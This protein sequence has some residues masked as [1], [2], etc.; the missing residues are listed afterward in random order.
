MTTL[1]QRVARCAHWMAYLHHVAVTPAVTRRTQVQEQLAGLIRRRLDAL[2]RD[3][4]L[5][6]R[7]LHDLLAAT[8]YAQLG[9]RSV[10]LHY[11][12]HPD[13]TDDAADPGSGRCPDG[14]DVCRERLDEEL[15]RLE[16]RCGSRTARA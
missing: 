9:D 2:E 13:S 11:L 10:A 6:A 8:I 7:R 14:T 4:E 12:S 1:A 16:K 3:G 15:T 5:D